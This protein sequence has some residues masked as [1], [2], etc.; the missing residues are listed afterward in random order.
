MCADLENPDRPKWA[1][2]SQPT[3]EEK[4]VAGGGPG[5]YCGRHKLDV[6]KNIIIH[7]PEVATGLG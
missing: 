7:L 6:K 4:I 3:T 1:D 5:A 2:N